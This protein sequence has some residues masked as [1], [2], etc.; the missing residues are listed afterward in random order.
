MGRRREEKSERQA[1][2]PGQVLETGCESD[3][4]PTVGLEQ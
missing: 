4:L 2:E 3:G 1:T